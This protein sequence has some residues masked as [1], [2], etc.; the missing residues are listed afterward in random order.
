MGGCGALG[1][2]VLWDAV[3]GVRGVQ[4]SQLRTHLPSSTPAAQCSASPLEPC[5]AA[6]L[7]R[8][9]TLLPS[10]LQRLGYSL[11]ISP[12]C[13]PPSTVP[14]HLVFQYLL[15]YPLQLSLFLSIS[16]PLPRSPS[17]TPGV[18]P[19]MASFLAG[20]MAEPSADVWWMGEAGQAGMG[21]REEEGEEGEEERG[22][23]EGRAPEVTSDVSSPLRGVVS[24]GAM[25]GA[26][27]GEE[28]ARM[29]RPEV[30]ER[31][32]SEVETARGASGREG[33]GEGEGEEGVP[34]GVSGGVGGV[35]SGEGEEAFEF[36][37]GL[38]PTAAA[39]AGAGAGAGE[40]GEGPAEGFAPSL[41]ALLDEDAR[42][43]ELAALPDGESGG[44]EERHGYKRCAGRYVSGFQC[45][46][47]VA[48]VC[49]LEPQCSC[50]VRC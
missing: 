27:A 9:G 30:G 50:V 36:E 13:I 11:G 21:E 22:E 46:G 48:D 4:C 14:C 28:A 38:G 3:S 45:G 8:A 32:P 12:V 43:M 33:G 7:W 26:A 39:A 20:F 49:C 24:G 40:G 18:A 6:S 5:A 47:E 41:S 29:F 19:A 16:V 31:E 37:G 10:S 34:E 25:D 17:L 35:P 2:G 15:S 44:E 1:V 42:D 23:E